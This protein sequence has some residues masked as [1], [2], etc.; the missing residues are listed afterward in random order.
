M[1]QKFPTGTLLRGLADVRVLHVNLHSIDTLDTSL[2][3]TSLYNP[4]PVKQ[5][6]AETSHPNWGDLQI[7]DLRNLT[8]CS[9]F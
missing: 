1:L 6:T 7:K 3:E 2:Q 9:E 4:N 5:N 8:D